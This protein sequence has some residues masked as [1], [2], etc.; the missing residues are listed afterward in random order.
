MHSQVL[1]KQEL[2]QYF[3]DATEVS[4]TMAE[5][6]GNVTGKTVLEPSVGSGSLLRVLQGRPERVDAVDID[7]T[8][9]G[10]VK[11]RLPGMM[12]NTYCADFI[13][14]HLSSSLI[15]TP[16]VH[17]PGGY[18]AVISNPPFG[19]FF[20]QD[21]RRQLKQAFPDLYVRESYGLFFV[22]S[23]FLLKPGGRFVFLMPDTFLT[24]KNHAPLRRFICRSAAVSNVVRFPSKRFETVNFAYGNLCIIAGDKRNVRPEDSID[25]IEAFDSEYPLLDQPNSNVSKLAGSDLLAHLEQGWRRGMAD[26]PEELKDWVTLGD[27]AECKTGIYTGDNKRFIGYD[28]A[29]VKKR[30]NG[31]AIQWETDIYPE[32]LSDEQKVKGLD[33]SPSYVPLIR[34][35]HRDFDEITAWAI[36]WDR[37]SVLF[38]K[39]DKKA[40]LQNLGYYFKPGIAVPMVTSKRLTASLMSGAVFDQGVVGVFPKKLEDLSSLLIYLNSSIASKLRNEI[41]NG[42]ANNSANY[43]KRIPV[44]RFS[45]SANIAADKILEDAKNKRILTQEQCDEFIE[46][47]TKPD[48]M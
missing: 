46:R 20:T 37:E 23:I 4:S 12:I 43:L 13:D 39:T 33:I 15:S 27:L 11:R 41:V 16:K 26:S 29:R 36:K 28:P 5:L 17:L 8:I 6:L 38:Y 25:W 40:R 35:G 22:L 44:P 45:S 47:I 10:T 7:S 2:K 3:T 9:L 1:A 24:S 42:S 14:L 30:L 48:K 31:H 21:Y 32:S 19:L 34:G 18:D